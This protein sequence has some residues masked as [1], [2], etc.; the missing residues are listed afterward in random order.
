VRDL[1][2]GSHLTQGDAEEGTL[3]EAGGPPHV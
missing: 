1:L 3:L 2:S